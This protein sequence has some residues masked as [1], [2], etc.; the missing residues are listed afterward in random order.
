MEN[1]KY[2]KDS[3]KG[4]KSLEDTY[5]ML[6][7]SA[8]S[9]YLYSVLEGYDN[10]I[11]PYMIIL[12]RGNE[13]TSKV[14][15]SLNGKI[16]TKPEFDIVL[17]LKENRVFINDHNIIVLGKTI[18]YDK[19]RDTTKYAYYSYSL[20]F[21]KLKGPFDDFILSLERQIITLKKGDS[22]G[23]M[24][25]YG[26]I[27]IPFGKYTW[28]DGFYC[29]YVRARHGKITNGQKD[30]DANWC[31]ID[32]CGK[33]IYS[34]CYDIYFDKVRKVVKIKQEFN[35]QETQFKLE[36]GFNYVKRIESPTPDYDPYEGYDYNAAAREQ[37]ADAFDGDVDAY[38]N[39]D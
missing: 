20:C 7:T 6:P 4:L 5:I 23:V 32:Y 9:D 18:S 31:L 30:N 19:E 38:W 27:I 37:I 33:E 22:W 13:C 8:I 17:G 1:P 11:K 26:T 15:L 3:I 10:I 35:G 29:G 24:D 34:N 28:I 25:C 21:G 14:G 2:K 16:L 12:K 36:S 39:I